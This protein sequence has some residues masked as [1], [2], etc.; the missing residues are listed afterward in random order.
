MF[1]KAR[2]KLTGWYLL[3]I[4]AISLSFSVAIYAGV[5][6]ELVRISDLQK[7]RQM[8]VDTISTFL[9]QNGVP[10][11]PEIQSLD[12]ESLEQARLR[13]ISALGLINLSI[14]VL[15][16]LGGYLLAGLTLN[17]I[18]K[19]V[20][21]QKE[22]V[23]N[24]S[25]ELRTP[26]TSLKTEIEVALRDKKLSIADAKKLLKSNLEDVNNMQGLSNYLLELNRYEN[27]ETPLEITEI[28]LAEA[29][30]NAVKKVEPIA[31]KNKIKIVA[32]LSK[33]SVAGNEDAVIELSTIL[34]DNAIKY[35]G[36]AKT[37]EV[38]TTSK[39]ILEV[40][41]FGIGIPEPDIPHIFERFYRGDTSRSRQKVDG[42]GLGLSIAKSI[43]EKLDGKI[44][45]E[46]KLGRGTTFTISFPMS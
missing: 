3:I 7:V 40:K 43:V 4:M 25:H 39:G 11:P 44:K 14:L 12:S 42:Y 36:K 33:S 10:V 22:F 46:S 15:S 18:S 16:G 5:N 38:K 1:K 19:M 41:D 29:V 9:K 23:G 17:P 26:L 45:V 20:Q 32:K 30:L 6:R 8:K 2:I 37:V 34:I 24:A 21:E 28:D 13:I 31:A 27:S 35:S